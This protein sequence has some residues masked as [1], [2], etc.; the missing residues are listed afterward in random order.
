MTVRAVLT[1]AARTVA[2]PCWPRRLWVPVILSPRLTWHLPAAPR[3]F[4]FG[5]W[6]RES[7]L[8]PRLLYSWP[9][10]RLPGR[11]APE[12]SVPRRQERALRVG[13]EAPKEY[14]AG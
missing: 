5:I 8:L 4:K 1:W 2:P 10:I 9:T 6:L 11:A 13:V 3:K 12:A 14:S 7:R